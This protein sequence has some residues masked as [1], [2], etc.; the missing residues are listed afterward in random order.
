[1]RRMD[2]ITE[3]HLEETGLWNA[4]LSDRSPDTR[5]L[6]IQRYMHTAQRIAAS[7]F[8]QRPFYELEFSDYL[9]YARVGL[10]EAIDKYNPARGATF[11]TYAG[12]RIKGSILNGIEANSELAAQSA[13][14]RRVLKER[15]VSVQQV[16]E[17][18]SSEQEDPFEIL[19]RT[20][21]DL[22]LGHVLEEPLT[23]QVISTDAAHDPYRSCELKM[24][25]DRLRLIVDALPERERN[26]I[27]G[28]YFEHVDFQKLAS[29]MGVTKGRVSQL[30]ARGLTLVREACRQME[31]FDVSA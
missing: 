9:Q 16:L 8:A 12:Y 10:L 30:H 27:K 29:R 7:M 5:N 17:K 26:V 24:L 25:S 21:I 14:R 13:F 23:D 20:A 22:A 1:M 4:F 28:H 11:Q 18:D 6:L 19:A 15:V 2:Q 3:D 31:N